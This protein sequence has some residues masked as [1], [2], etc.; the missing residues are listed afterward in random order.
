MLDALPEAIVCID[1]GGAIVG[2]WGSC[3]EI[4]GERSGDLIGVN[5][6]SRVHPDDVAYAAGAL[7]EAIT[8]TGEHIP[9]NLRIVTADGQWV[10]TE[11]AAGHIDEPG[12]LLISLR[13]LAYRGH[14]DERRADLQRR[15]LGIASSVAAAH[16]D[17]LDEALVAAVVSINAFFHTAATKFSAPGAPG[18]EV[19]DLIEWP[20]PTQLGPGDYF[21]HGRIGDHSIIEVHVPADGDARWWLAWRQIDPGMAGWDGSHLD[22]LGLAGAVTASACARLVLEADL[23]RRSK[24]DALTGLANR[25]ELEHSLQEMLDSGPATVLFCD[26]DGF[27]AVNDRFGHAFGDR[28]L[29]VVAQRLE[30][31][32]RAGDVMGRVGGDEFIAAC[33]DLTPLDEGDV[34]ARLH[35]ALRTPVR[36][37]GVDVDVRVSV[38]SASGLA[39]TSAAALIAQA[40]AAMYT[41][42]ARKLVPGEATSSPPSPTQT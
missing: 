35:A 33:R 15:C 37:A 31:V 11:A 12:L 22:D 9:V 29:V 27:K 39:G 3:F 13:P 32:L 34:V 40:D 18:I 42:K 10:L 41:A 2:A 7:A 19:G 26:L 17:Q 20:Q 16:G 4:F 23:V 5:A 1:A 6:Y 21:D 38:G 8:R 25:P 24:E 30:R 36:V 28:V 14:M